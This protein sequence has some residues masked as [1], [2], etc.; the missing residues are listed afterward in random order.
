MACKQKN[1][2]SDSLNTKAKQGVTLPFLIW[3]ETVSL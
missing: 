3:P 1:V 2:H